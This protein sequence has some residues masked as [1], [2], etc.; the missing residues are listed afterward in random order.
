MNCY[1][2]SYCTIV[3]GHVKL[4]GQK[5]LMTK[6]KPFVMD[7]FFSA[8]YKRLGIDYRKFYKMDALSKLGFLASEILLKGSDREQPKEKMGI[9]LFN[10]SSSLEADMCF[11]KTIQHQED[12]Y[13]S[14]AEFV[15]TLPNI[16]AGEIAIRHKIQGETAFYVIERVYYDTISEMTNDAMKYAGINCALAGW[17]EVDVLNNTLNCFLMLC[18]SKKGD[19]SRSHLPLGLKNVDAYNNTLLKIETFYRLYN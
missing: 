10:R 1:I 15:Y 2:Q 12:F 11:Q 18:T 7:D 3:P 17:V 4:N 16:V 9:I 6:S 14:P 5:F 19:E 8:I 13:P